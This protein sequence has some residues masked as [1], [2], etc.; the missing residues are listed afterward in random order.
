MFNLQPDIVIETQAGP[1][2]LDTK[3]KE[4]DHEDGRKLGV[5]QTDVYQILM[6]GQAYNAERLVLLYPWRSGLEEGIN[7]C[8]QVV[9]ANRRLDIATVDVG[10]PSRVVTALRKIVRVEGEALGKGV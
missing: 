7:R 9:S 4:L 2:V 3:W 8:W 1:I 10:N 6:Y 5:T